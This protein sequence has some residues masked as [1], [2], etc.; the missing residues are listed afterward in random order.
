MAKKI[1]FI[2]LLLLTITGV[3][4]QTYCYHCYKKYDNDIPESQ[5]YYHYFTFQGN[6]LYP[7]EFATPYVNIYGENISQTYFY[8]GKKVDG[9]KYYGYIIPQSNP[10]SND[11]FAPNMMYNMSYYLVSSDMN[12]INY[13]TTNYSNNGIVVYC[14]EK[15]PDKNCKKS[16]GPNNQIP[17]IRQ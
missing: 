17:A 9:A 10:L 15:C 4:A 3:K 1:I 12:I 16:T 6:Y 5:D 11:I 2:C 14:Y 8:N 13:V 7:S